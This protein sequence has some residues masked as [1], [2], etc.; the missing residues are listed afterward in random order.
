[1]WDEIIAEV[2][3]HPKLQGKDLPDALLSAEGDPWQR[4][5]QQVPALAAFLG[6]NGIKLPADL[7]QFSEQGRVAEFLRRSAGQA[8]RQTKE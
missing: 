8:S 7:L 6:E 3:T 5:A 4:H 1:M 2:R